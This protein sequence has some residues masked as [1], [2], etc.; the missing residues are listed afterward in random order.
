MIFFDAISSKLDIKFHAIMSLA[1][2]LHFNKDEFSTAIKNV[3]DHL[4][5]KG[6]FALL[7]KNGDLEGYSSYKMEGLRYFKHWDI[8]SLQ[9]ELFDYFE[10]I[11]WS[12]AGND[13][14]IRLILRKK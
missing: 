5:D 14:W 4:Y 6:V 8:E 13:K 3:H 11:H 1:V 7:L 10:T 12:F 2:F 9:L